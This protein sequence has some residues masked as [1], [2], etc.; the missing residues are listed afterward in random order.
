M[1]A[2]VKGA[3]GKRTEL[4][5]ERTGAVGVTKERATIVV[6]HRRCFGRSTKGLGP[7]PN[8]QFRPLLAFMFNILGGIPVW[9]D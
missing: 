9:I 7:V 8:G 5:T 6:A 1:Q 3:A 4:A 2:R